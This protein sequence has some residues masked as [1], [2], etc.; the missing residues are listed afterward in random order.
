MDMGL[1]K[2]GIRRPASLAEDPRR[3][4]RPAFMIQVLL[5]CQP[6]HNERS[7]QRTPI[8]EEQQE[9]LRI[10]DYGKGSHLPWLRAPTQ[11]PSNHRQSGTNDQIPP[12]TT[13]YPTDEP[14]VST[15]QE[16]IRSSKT[17]TSTSP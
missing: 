13:T 5:R 3:A 1:S 12:H 15:H 16:T 7:Y 14:Q 8:N 17:E 9:D 4:N 6:R 2:K 11:L 10:A